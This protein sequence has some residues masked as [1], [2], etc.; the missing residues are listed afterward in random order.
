MSGVDS[1]LEGL[2]G[3]TIFVGV[4]GGVFVSFWL[5]PGIGGTGGGGAGRF[6]LSAAICREGGGGAL[7][8][9]R[10]VF[11]WTSSFLSDWKI[12]MNK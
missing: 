12:D 4:E 11:L 6:S 3:V 9:S 2:D 1:I 7:P 8:L 10:E 5:T